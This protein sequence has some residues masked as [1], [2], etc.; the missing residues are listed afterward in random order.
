MLLNLNPIMSIIFNVPS[1]I[2]STVSLDF[3]PYC[4]NSCLCRTRSSQLVLFVVCPTSCQL[5]PSALVRQSHR[6]PSVV[7]PK[8]LELTRLVHHTPSIHKADR[9]LMLPPPRSP[10]PWTPSHRQHQGQS[11]SSTTTRLRR[12]TLHALQRTSRRNMVPRPPAPVH[13]KPRLTSP[14]SPYY[15]F[16]VHNYLLP[17]GLSCSAD[18]TVSPRGGERTHHILF[19]SAFT[20]ISLIILLSLLCLSLS[21]SRSFL[22]SVAFLSLALVPTLWN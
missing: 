15:A 19:A 17:R 18:A 12:V 21:A 13:S 3:I 1:A 9:L 10:C 5:S 11:P 7:V 14:H 2:A 6:W 4:G 20:F 22:Q 16:F 8:H